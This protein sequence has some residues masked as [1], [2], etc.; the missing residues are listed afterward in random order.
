MLVRLAPSDTA[1]ATRYRAGMISDAN[2]D[3]GGSLTYD[4]IYDEAETANDQQ[5]A[6]GQEE[7]D[8]EDGVAAD[9]VLGVPASPCVWCAARL[10]LARCSFRRGRHSEV[11]RRRRRKGGR[12]RSMAA[13][14]WHGEAWVVFPS[15][16]LSCRLAFC[17][18][19]L[20]EASFFFRF[21]SEFFVVFWGESGGAPRSMPRPT[22][23][24][25]LEAEPSPLV[26]K[27]KTA[28]SEYTPIRAVVC[29]WWRRAR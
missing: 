5:G 20:L 4:V 23:A 26:P 28:F 7:E 8:E 6:A 24:V 29:R 10:N 2:D 22:H 19:C 25:L 27:H 13:F 12:G 14:M 15:C 17:G 1:S 11:R 18:S 16:S 9:R 3:G 21:S